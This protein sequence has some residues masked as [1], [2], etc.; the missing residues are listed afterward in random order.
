MVLVPARH[1]RNFR[2]GI[3]PFPV[4]ANGSQDTSPRHIGT[5]ERHLKYLFQILRKRRARSPRTGHLDVVFEHKKKRNRI[6]YARC[7]V[8]GRTALRNLP[9][10]FCVCVN[11]ISKY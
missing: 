5:N 8:V 7:Q 11:R 3:V 10:Q 9:R 6:R 1:R 2:T 4:R